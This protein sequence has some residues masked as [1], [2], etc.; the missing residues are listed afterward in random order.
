VKTAFIFMLACLT[1]LVAWGDEE[2]IIDPSAPHHSFPHYW[3]QM[4]GSG[5]AILTL[6]DSY[7]RDLRAVKQATDFKFVRFHAIFHDEVG[8]YDEDKHG[9]A[10]YNFSYVD[11]IYD[12]LLENGVRPFVELSFMP[13]KLAAREAVHS[14]KYHPIVAPPRDYAKWD[15]MIS[16]FAAHVIERYGIDEV[17]Q[18]YFEVWNEPNL[19]FWTG[20]PAQ[21]S[22]WTLYDHTAKALK[23]VDARLRVGGPSTAQAAWV[24]GFIRHATDRGVPLDF[25]STHVYAN[26]N[27]KDVF[28]TREKIPRNEMVCR[29]AKKVRDEVNA[30]GRPELPIVWSEYGATYFNEPKITDTAFMGPWLADTLRRCDGLADMM[31]YWTFSDVFEEQGV[32][33]RPFYG[34]F[35]LITAGGIPKPVF[36]AFKMLH[37]LGA[38]RLD[39]DSD[40]ALVTRRTDGALVIALWN[41]VAPGESGVPT[42]ISLRLPHEAVSARVLRLDA[43]HGDAGGEY[44]RM[45]SPRYPTSAQ[46][47]TL[48]SASAL[49]PA[50]DLVIRNER[51]AVSLPP[52]GLATVEVT[53]KR[54]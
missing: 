19:D 36:N 32:V 37:Q 30:S 10:I 49:P 27:A 47:H 28:A 18:W 1:P 2:V 33:Q 17:A 45:G 39:A 12:G 48:T 42:T 31:S 25:V 20:T 7:R 52:N 4:F 15:A 41:Y 3:E 53:L 50:E 16:A 46:L 24:G 29:A 34:G 51:A 26:D 8:V 54:P 14:F 11:Q 43:E 23:S 9:K 21:T 22:Y 38:E 35:G 5:R 13:R 40:H 6:R 44:A